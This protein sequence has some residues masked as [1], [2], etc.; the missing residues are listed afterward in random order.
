MFFYL[1]TA[2]K[3]RRMTLKYR[4]LT[5]CNCS[6]KFM[7]KKHTRSPKSWSDNKL[8]TKITAEEL[9]MEQ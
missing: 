6:I 9:Y 8:N 1:T 7:S 2:G 4:K 5:G 3:Q